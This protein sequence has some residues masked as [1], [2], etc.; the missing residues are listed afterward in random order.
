[1]LLLPLPLPLLVLATGPAQTTLCSLQATS[2][3]KVFGN[4]CMK[5][6]TQVQDRNLFSSSFQTA[7]ETH[8]FWILHL[9]FI[10]ASMAALSSL[11]LITLY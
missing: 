2:V 6:F 8:M 1:M 5:K 11:G 4:L 9:S 7:P 3:W 10:I